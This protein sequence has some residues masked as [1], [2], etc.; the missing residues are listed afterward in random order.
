MQDKNRL[1]NFPIS[2]FAAVMGLAGLAIASLSCTSVP[3][4]VLT[5]TSANDCFWC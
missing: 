3:T 2:F 5:S 1:A 4:P